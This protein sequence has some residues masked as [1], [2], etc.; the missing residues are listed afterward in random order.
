MEKSTKAVLFGFA[1]SAL[2]IGVW[3]YI[4]VG[5]VNEARKPIL[6]PQQQI[7]EQNRISANETELRQ[8]E[9][10]S[11][12]LLL[13]GQFFAVAEHNRKN[14][15]IRLRYSCTGSAQWL[16]LKDLAKKTDLVF[17][18]FNYRVGDSHGNVAYAVASNSYNRC[19][20]AETY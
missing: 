16:S 18:V 20:K 1:L 5:L 3:Y 9:K 8:S 4:G 13:D 2:A 17:N 7:A 6:T 10:G 11:I 15:T 12:V 19:K 14:R